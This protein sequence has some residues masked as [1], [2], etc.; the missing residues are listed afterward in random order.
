MPKKNN[1]TVIAVC[2]QEPTEDGSTM[3]LGAIQ[4]DELRFLHQAFIT[5]TLVNALQVPSVDVRL[6]HI[7][8]P[9]R[10]RLVKIVSDYITGKIG[11]KKKNGLTEHFLSIG[12]ANERWGLR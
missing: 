2:I 7:D 4:G 11:A 1:S 5:D 6:Y 12:M 3:D 9:E 10:N 8:E